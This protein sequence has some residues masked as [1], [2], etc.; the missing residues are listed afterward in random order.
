MHRAMGSSLSTTNRKTVK[1]EY[2]ARVPGVH[3][4]WVLLVGVPSLL[5]VDTGGQTGT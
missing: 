2:N 3:F 5:T 1:E 4:F